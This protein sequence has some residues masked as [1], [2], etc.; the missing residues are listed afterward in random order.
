[1]PEHPRNQMIRVSNKDDDVLLSNLE[2]EIINA[3]I[4]VSLHLH[5]GSIR[6]LAQSYSP[7]GIIY[8]II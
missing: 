7:K 2:Y 6:D 4:N 3:V 1:M 8:C 5:G